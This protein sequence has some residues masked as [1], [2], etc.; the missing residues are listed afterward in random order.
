MTAEV[1]SCGGGAFQVE[2]SIA[3]LKLQHKKEV[4]LGY[5]GPLEAYISS[6]G[7][8]MHYDVNWDEVTC[9]CPDFKFRQIPCKHIFRVRSV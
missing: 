8:H 1:V 3:T 9:T 7:P 6:D 2:K 5:D 4:E